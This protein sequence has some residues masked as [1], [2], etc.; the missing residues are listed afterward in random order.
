MITHVAIEA[1]FCPSPP[2]FPGSPAGPT[3]PVAPAVPPGPGAPG[4]PAGP[5]GPAAPMSP[6]APAGPVSPWG[7]LVFH[8]SWLSLLEHTW[9]ASLSITRRVPPD[10]AKQPVI[11]PVVWEGIDA[12]ASLVT[13]AMEPV[14]TPTSTTPS[15]PSPGTAHKWRTEPAPRRQVPGQAHAVPTG[16]HDRIATPQFRREV[17]CSVG[18]ERPQR[19]D[20]VQ[21]GSTSVTAPACRP[22][23]SCRGAR[24]SGSVVPGAGDSFIRW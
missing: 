10:F 19:A 6:W 1:G 2:S 22:G 20:K 21:R 24:Q 9:L 14:R 12:H 4:P 13:K 16:V 18:R 11:S 3:G 23:G 17:A 15:R 5:A 8:T 7:P